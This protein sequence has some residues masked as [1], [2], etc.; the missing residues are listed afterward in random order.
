MKHLPISLAFTVALFL[1]GAHAGKTQSRAAAQADGASVGGQALKTGPLTPQASNTTGTTPGASNIWGSTYTG[2]ADA[3][4]TK[5]QDSSS[6]IGIGNEARSD[7]VS[8]FQGYNANRDTQA[9]QATY[10]LDRNPVLKPQISPTDPM[11]NTSNVTGSAGFGSSTQKVCSQETTTPQRKGQEFSCFQSYL[12][13]VVT[14]TTKANVWVEK[15][16]SC[17]PGETLSINMGDSTGMGRDGFMGGDVLIAEWGCTTADY[18]NITMKTN[19]VKSGYV[20]GVVPNN[21][22][23]IIVENSSQALK[24]IN[25]TT[26]TDGQCTGTYT[27]ILGSVDPIYTYPSYCSWDPDIGMYDASGQGQPCDPTYVGSQFVEKSFGASSRIT[28]RGSFSMAHIVTT[29]T[30]TDDC[31]PYRALAN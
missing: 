24:F 28:S 27:M 5:K 16:P 20:G 10:F 11:L 23:I 12:P 8:S 2:A 19:G 6:L 9:S 13:Y 14:C 4:L 30:I 21:G 7:A 22:E 26:C 31:D 25:Q 3:T 18:P 29:T 1:P 17:T 15:V